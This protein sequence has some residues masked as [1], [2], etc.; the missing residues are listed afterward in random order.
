[1]NRQKLSLL[2]ALA[3]AL[4][5]ALTACGSSSSNNTS[6]SSS[7]AAN[8]SPGSSST[9]SSSR[10]AGFQTIRYQTTPGEVATIELASYL[11]YLPGIRITSVG[12]VLGGPGS[13]AATATGADDI[14]GAFN[15]SIIAAIAAGAKLKAVVGD[16]GSDAKAYSAVL[17]KSSSPI[18]NARDLIGKTV[19]VNTLGANATEV[20]DLWLAKQ[21]L[22]PAQIKQVEFVVV[23][24]TQAAEALET[25]RVD[26]AFLSLDDF[27]PVLKQG[28]VRSLMTDIGVLGPYT[29]GSWVL[30]PSFIQSHPAETKELVTGLAKAN[31]WLQV[32]PRAQAVAVQEK[33][34]ALH[35]RGS[36]AKFVAAWQSSGVAEPYGYIKPSDFSEWLAP[37]ESAGQLKQGQVTLSQL[38]TNEFNAYAPH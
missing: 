36:D 18:H 1:L 7:N 21:G 27:E 5:L 16:Y 22:T 3:A 26:A 6:A 38:Y 17:V 24:P 11:G 30:N 28:E 37:M 8:V 29:G 31:H 13:I 32:T 34:L 12:V 20:T 35:G 9:S 2:V 23:S 10:A 14:G 33:I 15:G 19:G 4:A 25:G